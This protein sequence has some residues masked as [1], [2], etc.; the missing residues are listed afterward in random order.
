MDR[1][2]YRIASPPP[3]SSHFL[4]CILLGLAILPK[5]FT[6]KTVQNRVLCFILQKI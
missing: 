4:N 6:P 2:S 1:K 3:A 5:P